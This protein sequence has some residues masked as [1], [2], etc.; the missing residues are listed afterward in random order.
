[1]ETIRELLDSK[2]TDVWSVDPATKVFDALKLMAEK[3]IGA[4]LVQDSAAKLLGIF[5]ERDYA[6]K[7]VLQGKTSKD[8]TVGDIMTKRVVCVHPDQGIRDCMA[9]ITRERVRHLPV[10]DD[11][12]VLG[13]VSIGDI[14]KSIIDNQD[15]LI[16]Q[17]E[18][19]IAGSL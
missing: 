18:H 15:L 7:I 8:T 4:L 13:V 2:G 14:V 6:R 17:L 19:Y 5:S 16:K 11:G 12:S 3:N 10:I 1:M 9:L